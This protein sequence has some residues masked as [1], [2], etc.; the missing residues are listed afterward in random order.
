MK[1]VAQIIFFL[2]LL[3]VGLGVYRDYGI[4]IDETVSRENGAVTLKYAA[5]RFAPSLLTRAASHLKPLNEYA[6]RIYGVAFEAPAVALEIMLGVGDKKNVFMFRH[7]LTFLVAL[8]GIYAVQR[9]AERR[10][11][12]WRIGLLAALFL[13]LTP[14]LFAESFYNSKDVVFMAFYAIAMNTT[15]AFVLKP[16]L[17]I[18]FLHALA[19]AVAIDVRIMA[20]ILRHS[21]NPDRQIVEAGIA[22]PRNVSGF[23]GL[24][25]SRLHPRYS[26]VAVAVV[27]SDPQF[28][29]SLQVHV[30]IPMGGVKYFI[31]GA[32][33]EAP[34]FRGTTSS[35]GYRSQLRCYISL[36]SSWEHPTL[37]ARLRPRAQVC[38]RVTRNCRTRSISA[39]LLFPS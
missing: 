21:S 22:Y 28:R 18:A 20:V 27:Q 33:F 25:G 13:V 26:D 31:W 35:Y 3:A 29:S 7:L 30:E 1:Y 11:S 16:R 23:G 10:F 17:K 6:D 37:F 39:C 19:S 9:M 5:E 32:T 14:R 24:P 2:G 15:I 4:S 36:C 8:A 38:G 34:I 12:D